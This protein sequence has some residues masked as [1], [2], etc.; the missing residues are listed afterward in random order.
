MSKYRN[1]QKIVNKL[2]FLPESAKAVMG[3]VTAS[4]SHLLSLHIDNPAGGFAVT[5]MVQKCFLAILLS[6]KSPG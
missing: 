3:F 2:L 6:S 1:F 4:S 5:A